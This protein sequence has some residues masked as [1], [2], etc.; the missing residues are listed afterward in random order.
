NSLFFL[1]ILIRSSLRVARL[2]FVHLR[3]SAA[4]LSSSQDDIRLNGRLRAVLLFSVVIWARF[5]G[6]LDYLLH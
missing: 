1:F 3:A 4:Y 5:F 2:L 6:V